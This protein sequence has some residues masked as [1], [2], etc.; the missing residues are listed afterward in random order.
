MLR[1]WLYTGIILVLFLVLVFGVPLFP[2]FMAIDIAGPMNFGMLIFL[3]LH[4]LTPT[5]AFI[6]LKQVHGE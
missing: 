5:L 3:L 6:Y 2:E 1:Q 4:M